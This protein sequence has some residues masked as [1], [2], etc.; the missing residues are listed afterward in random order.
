[1]NTLEN[2]ITGPRGNFPLDS[3]LHDV[4]FGARLLRKSPG[5]TA[6]AVL[7][8]ALGIGAN[9]AVF[10]VVERLLLRPLPY[11]HPEELVQ[12]SNSYL[13]NFTMLGL[14]PGDYQDWKREARSFSQ[15]GAY[16]EVSQGFNLS[17]AGDPQRVVAA[18]VTSSLFPTLGVQALVGRT[19][20]ADDDKPSGPTEVLLTERFWRSRFAADPAVVGRGVTLDGRGYT[21]I[22]ILPAR[23]HLL[24]WPDIWL[25]IGQYFDDLNEH[26][27]HGFATIA[28]LN[29][30]ATFASARAEIESL[31]RQ[32]TLAYPD[33]HKHW[34]VE[35]Q[36]LE[37]SSA[38][39]LRRTLLVLFGAV[40][41]VLLIACAN[42]TFLLM[43]RNATRERELA[44][45][46]ALGA[47]P[48]RVLRQLLT[49]SVLLAAIGGA[50]GLLLALAANRILVALTPSD[51]AVVGETSLDP[52]IL[53]FTAAVCLAVGILSGLL[54][55]LQARTTRLAAFLNPGSKGGGSFGRHRIHHVLVA[56]EIALALAPLAGAGLLLRSLN[57][58]LQV[59]PGFRAENL[60][61]MEVAQAALPFAEANKLTPAEQVELA[62]KQSLEFEQLAGRIEALP[63]VTAAGGISTLPL[64]SELREA[65]RFIVEGQP[66]P[67]SGV[68]P[69]A[70]IRT[71]SLGYFAVAGIPV[72]RGRGF[73]QDDWSHQNIV[74]SETL[75]RRF[76]PGRDPLNERLNFCSLDPKPCWYS[77]VGVVGNVRQ[78]G[79]DSPA[80]Y[81]AYFTGGWTNHL[82][83]RTAGDPH[84]VA[85][86]AAEVI[87]KSDPALP[88]ARVLSMEELLAGSV[89]ARRFSAVLIGI[90]AALAL[91]LA[92]VGTY[93]VMNTSVRHRTNE[94][95]IRMAL[96]AQPAAVLRSIVGQGARLALVGVAAGS[97]AAL[98]IAPLISAL[99]F[100]VAPH[101]PATFLGAAALLVAV[102]LMACYLP[103]RRAMRVDPMVALRHE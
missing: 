66:L 16:V 26:V 93:G 27:H 13:P 40:G 21:V 33:S 5:F 83:I 39:K 71:A 8:L 54:P 25:P 78:L 61:T 63:G 72:V 45:R 102:A 65:S 22:G 55:A 96:G 50:A 10:S 2:G 101:D 59:D 44:L 52:A 41:L 92:A 1:V 75:A 32:E 90:F 100:G 38:R 98:A 3:F 43:A 15:M 84:A 23:S 64:N 56:A 103:A 80:T 48:G 94:I 47:G 73:L 70:Q 53:G 95:A 62:K 11:P 88:I 76:F 79:L 14:S 91:L 82:V 31:N 30:G 9:T 36:R 97:A 17:G 24:S 20:S 34:S 67:E 28:R 89:A 29:Q 37:D 4:R 68:L 99:L 85:T 19:F 86:A 42:I 81:D 58:V 6:V 7:T 46:T 12:I 35:T 69:V 60:L 18:Y 87:R 49:E 57:H 51:L 77:I 74:I